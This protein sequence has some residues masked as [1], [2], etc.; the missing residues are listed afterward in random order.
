MMRFN[1]HNYTQTHHTAIV[2][3]KA[4][5]QCH[6]FLSSYFMGNTEQITMENITALSSG[7]SHMRNC[8]PN[9]RVLHSLKLSLVLHTQDELGKY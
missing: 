2:S 1:Q 4:V 3:A 7:E 5:I 9:G 8:G 6:H